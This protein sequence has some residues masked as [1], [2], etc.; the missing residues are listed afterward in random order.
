[1]EGLPIAFFLKRSFPRLHHLW[2]RGGKPWKTDREKDHPDFRRFLVITLRRPN[3]AM[4]PRCAMRFESHTPKSLAMWKVFSLAMQNTLAWSEFTRKRQK[5]PLQKSSDVGLR[6]G[7][8]ACFL[9]SIDA[10]V[11]DSDYSLRFGLRCECL[12]YQ[13]A[14]D[15]GRAMR[16][17]KELQHFG[18]T[19][20][21]RRNRRKPERTFNKISC[22]NLV[23]YVVL[24]VSN[25]KQQCEFDLWPSKGGF[26]RAFWRGPFC[27]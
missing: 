19:D 10:N 12:R 21:R 20:F 15:V 4:Q 18:G 23:V 2:S 27:D 3:R 9:R 16:A 7:K 6:C 22:L 8:S 17:T 25:G 5:N 1:M 24:A 14:S 11:C 26:C 13:I